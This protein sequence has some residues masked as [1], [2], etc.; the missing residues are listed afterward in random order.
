M[1]KQV[2]A[3][4]VNDLKPI[5]KSPVLIM[6]AFAAI[7]VVVGLCVGLWPCNHGFSGRMV[8]NCEDIDEC[9]DGSL[10]DC[11]EDAIC[12]NTIGSWVCACKAG[13]KGSG[14]KCVDLN[15]C[16]LGKSFNSIGESD[17]F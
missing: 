17:D 6:I 2:D 12:T 13:H 8:T 5:K 15:E 9:E 1:K 11:H 3:S 4:D 14:Q 10:H 7:A 16:I